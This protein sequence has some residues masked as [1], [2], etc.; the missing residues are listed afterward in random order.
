M[1]IY[2]LYRKTLS[3]CESF[4]LLQAFHNVMLWAVQWPDQFIDMNTPLVSEI[5]RMS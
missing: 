4:L 1:V 5:N 3:Y 2:G